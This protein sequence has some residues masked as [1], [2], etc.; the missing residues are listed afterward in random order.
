VLPEA[1]GLSPDRQIKREIVCCK[2]SSAS[3]FG[4][5]CAAAY[6]QLQQTNQQL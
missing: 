5:L 2:S 6:H 4:I 1:Q 3:A